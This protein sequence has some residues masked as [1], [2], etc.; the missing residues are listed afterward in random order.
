MENRQKGKPSTQI[1]TRASS[2]AKGFDIISPGSDFS[3]ARGLQLSKHAGVRGGGQKAAVST[4][5]LLSLPGVQS[6]SRITGSD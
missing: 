6:K 3:L 4:P 2:Q 5:Y 1:P